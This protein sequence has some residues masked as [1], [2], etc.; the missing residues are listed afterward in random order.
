MKFEKEK[1]FSCYS[2]KLKEFLEEFDFEPIEVFK[3]INTGKTCWV[4]EKDLPC[5]PVNMSNTKSYF[6]ERGNRKFRKKIREI[7][8]L[9]ESKGVGFETIIKDSSEIFDIFYSDI[10]QVVI[11]D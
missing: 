11:L 1:Y 10:Y 4:F 7:Q 3:N 5:P 6:T 8:K 2:P 9:A